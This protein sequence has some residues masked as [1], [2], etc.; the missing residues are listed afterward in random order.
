MEQKEENNEP[1]DLY[2]R[3]DKAKKMHISLDPFLI[4]KTFTPK[5]V[6]P[7]IFSFGV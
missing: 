5:N 3:E 7:Y 4:F 2:Q 6:F 1:V